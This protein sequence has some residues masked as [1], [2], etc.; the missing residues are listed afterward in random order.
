MRRKQKQV[1]HTIFVSISSP[2]TRPPRDS[3]RVRSP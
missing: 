3:S 2:V 1:S